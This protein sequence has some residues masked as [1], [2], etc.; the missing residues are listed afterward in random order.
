MR[1]LLDAPAVASLLPRRASPNKTHIE[2][3]IERKR[4]IKKL[5]SRLILFEGWDPRA[6]IDHRQTTRAE[7]HKHHRTTHSHGLVVWRGSAQEQNKARNTGR[8]ERNGE[9]EKVEKTRLLTPSLRLPAMAAT[10][11]EAIKQFSALMEQRESS[12]LVLV[13]FAKN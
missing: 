5:T 1:S 6:R 7:P 2:I 13:F 10:S 9:L 12:V 3:C 4:E 8:E 11:E